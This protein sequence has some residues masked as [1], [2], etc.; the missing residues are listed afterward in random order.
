MLNVAQ[1]DRTR[2]SDFPYTAAELRQI[3]RAV[4]NEGYPP[5][6]RH[7]IGRVDRRHP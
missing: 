5:Q 6:G 1:T 3:A 2:G 7:G 4:R